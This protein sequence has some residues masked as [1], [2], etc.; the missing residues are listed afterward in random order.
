MFKRFGA[1]G[2]AVV[3]AGLLMGVADAKNNV[4][5]FVGKT[6]LPGVLRGTRVFA[7]ADALLRAMGFAWTA[8]SDGYVLSRGTTGGPPLTG[9]RVTLHDGP[10]QAWA[11]TWKYQGEAWVDARL[12]SQGLGYIFLYNPSLSMAQISMP[13]TGVRSHA[14]KV[15]LRKAEKEARR[16]PTTHPATDWRAGSSSDDQSDADETASAGSAS[17]SGEGS[18]SGSRNDDP[19]V[20]EQLEYQTGH[21]GNLTGRVVLK[22]AAKVPVRD[23]YVYVS[24]MKPQGERA[25]TASSGQGGLPSVASYVKPSEPFGTF[26]GYEGTPPSSVSSSYP[27]DNQS[28]PTF[29]STPAPTPTP[30]PSPS[31]SSSPSKQKKEKVKVKKVLLTTLPAR[32][33]SV[34]EPGKTASVD[35]TW[36]NPQ[37]LDVTPEVKTEHDHVPYSR[38][39][40]AKGSEEGSAK[41]APPATVTIDYDRV[42]KLNL[43]GEQEGKLHGQHTWVSVCQDLGLNVNLLFSE[44]KVDPIYTAGPSLLPGEGKELPGHEAT[45]ELKATI[46]TDGKTTYAIAQ[47]SG[48]EAADKVALAVAGRMVWLPAM[49]HGL[50]VSSSL[51]FGLHLRSSKAQTATTDE[52]SKGDEHAG[53]ASESGTGNGSE[54]P[55]APPPAPKVVPGS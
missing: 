55:T 26:G 27:G 51:T 48:D 16:A 42:G 53:G 13:T 33:V 7:P 2:L 47:G 18:G 54:S 32:Y 24:I 12:L 25:A 28:T 10:R 22:N 44:P 17:S 5:V 20:V 40:P 9:S 6:S 41:P 34:I 4:T 39:K 37:Q 30:A 31:P 46:G 52:G 8:S 11:V 36:S 29:G 38:P 35:F 15:A 49:N 50:P 21:T 1:F 45:V 14:L 19:V 3:L 23:V 43:T